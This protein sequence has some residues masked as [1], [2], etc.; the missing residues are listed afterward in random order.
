MAREHLHPDRA[1][2]LMVGQEKE[3]EKGDP[4][5]PVQLRQLSSGN[6]TQLPLRDPLTLTPLP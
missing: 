1:V 2:I 3:I 4:T 5:H 6:I